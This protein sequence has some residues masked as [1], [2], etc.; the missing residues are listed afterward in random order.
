M[1][2]MTRISLFAAGVLVAG[3]V[4]GIAQSALAAEAASAPAVRAASRRP[5]AAKA[6]LK[7][8][9]PKIDLNSASVDD[10]VRL[11]GIGRKRAEAIVALRTK[12]P[13]RRVLEIRNIRGV[14]RKTL[15]RLLPLITVGPPQKAQK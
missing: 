3:T 2:R 5:F 13:F 12:R 1:K 10:L 7:P 15:Q 8:G 4:T 11:P 9:D 6:R 14:G